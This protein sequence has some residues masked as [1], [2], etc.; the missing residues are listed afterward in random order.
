MAAV[1]HHFAYFVSRLPSNRRSNCQNSGSLFVHGVDGA[2]PRIDVLAPLAGAADEVPLQVL[3]LH[4]AVAVVQKAPQRGPAQDDG[5]QPHRTADRETD[6][7]PIVAAH[8]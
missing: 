7:V 8:A 1:Y 6:V 3:D 2:P 5:A 4:R